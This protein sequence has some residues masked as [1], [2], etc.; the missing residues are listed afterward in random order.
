MNYENKIRNLIGMQRKIVYGESVTYCALT[1][2]PIMPIRKTSS[3]SGQV[4]YW[5]VLSNGKLDLCHIHSRTK[6]NL[7]LYPLFIDSLANIV[8][9]LNQAQMDTH[10]RN[11]PEHLK[12]P[13]L[14]LTGCEIFLGAEWANFETDL[15]GRHFINQVLNGHLVIHRKVIQNALDVMISDVKKYMEVRNG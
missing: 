9:G 8:L 13:E 1:G 12:V 7:Q 4:V 3:D 6:K 5:D 2:K 14:L 11:Y 10:T 15:A